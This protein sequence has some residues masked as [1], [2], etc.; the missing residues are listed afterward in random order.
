MPNLI[1]PSPVTLCCADTA[2]FFSPKKYAYGTVKQEPSPEDQQNL[3]HTPHLPTTEL[4]KTSVLAE[5]A[6]GFI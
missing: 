1:I 6:S 3:L 5:V 4:Y 2:F